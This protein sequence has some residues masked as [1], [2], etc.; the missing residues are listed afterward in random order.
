M[1]QQLAKRTIII[2]IV[3]FMICVLLI[4]TAST[5]ILKPKRMEIP[6]DNT[7]KERGFYAEPQNSLD[8]VFVGSSQLFSTINPTVLW[9]EQGITSYVLG[10]NEQPFSISYY[11]IMEALKYQKPKAIVLEVTFCNWGE[12]PREGVVRINFDDL[13]WG[14]AKIQ[15]I[16]NNVAPKD[17][18]YYFFELSKYHSRWD[19]LTAEDFMLKTVYCKQNPDKG[20]SPYE[21]SN[22]PAKTYGEHIPPAILDCRDTTAL[23]EEA[24]TWLAKMIELCEK[25]NVRLILLKTP[26]NGKIIQPVPAGE[27]EQAFEYIDGMAY[28]NALV[29][30]A[31]Q[32]GIEFLNMNLVMPGTNHNDVENAAK[33]TSYFGE[34]IQGI[35]EIE[36]KRAGQ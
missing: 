14:K 27:A 1:E 11:Y 31:A 25:E 5:M 13:R 19:Q 22:D 28:Y 36:D 24:L 34:W 15:G 6:Y 32:A 17:W 20:W 23:N 4:I 7:R 18:E 2:R 26:N 10:G 29:E 33:A 8:L 12:M 35:I 21:K 3:M 30:Y 9:Q 16:M